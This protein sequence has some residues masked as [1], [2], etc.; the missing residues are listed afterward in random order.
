MVEKYLVV[1]N[2]FEYDYD[3]KEITTDDAITDISNKI[4]NFDDG[5]AIIRK[6]YQA[7]YEKT[8]LADV[9]ETEEDTIRIEQMDELEDILR[10]DDSPGSFVFRGK[11]TIYHWCLFELEEDEESYN[12]HYIIIK[13]YCSMLDIFSLAYYSLIF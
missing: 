10:N 9:A 8:E 2:T 6:E 12:T 5:K 11:D 1:K 7:M 13:G 4:V 3:E